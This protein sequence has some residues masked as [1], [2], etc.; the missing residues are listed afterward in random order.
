MQYVMSVPWQ[1]AQRKNGYHS[2]KYRKSDEEWEL[3]PEIMRYCQDTQSVH[4]FTYAIRKGE[5]AEWIFP[6]NKVYSS[7][8]LNGLKAVLGSIKLPSGV[9]IPG[10][11]EAKLVLAS[12]GG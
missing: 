8:I 6:K 3:T 1:L 11:I 4:F 12:L 5:W 2:V 10:D 9:I 7:A